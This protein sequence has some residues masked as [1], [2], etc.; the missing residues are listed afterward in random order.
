MSKSCAET[1]NLHFYSYLYGREKY[2]K[3]V[4]NEAKQEELMSVTNPNLRSK[5][6]RGGLIGLFLLAVAII[7]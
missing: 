7:G 1:A 5:Y 2:K 6:I 4:I 3:T